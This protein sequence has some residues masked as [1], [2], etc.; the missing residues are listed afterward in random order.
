LDTFNNLVSYFSALAPQVRAVYQ[1]IEVK[2]GQPA[3]P[4]CEVVA[5]SPPVYIFLNN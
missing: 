4:E 3:K 2:E 1:L 5:G